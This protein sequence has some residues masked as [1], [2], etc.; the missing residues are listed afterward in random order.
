MMN[1]YAAY[2]ARPE[3]EFAFDT[4]TFR[5]IL[6]AYEGV[7]WDALGLPLP[8][9]DGWE[10][11]MG[12][13]GEMSMAVSAAPVIDADSSALFSMDAYTGA[14][15]YT[16]MSGYDALPL[17]HWRRR[18]APDIGLP[19]RGFCQSLQRASRRGDGLPGNA[20]RGD[21]RRFEN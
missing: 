2:I 17:A 14:D 18:A 20:G 5:T 9:E 15:G 16:A 19:A 6:E 7:H 4:P 3:N 13:S 12:A 10:G 21:G 11:E 1:N 8:E